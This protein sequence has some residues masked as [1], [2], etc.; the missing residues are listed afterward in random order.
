MD[1]ICC[2]YL[3][4][5]AVIIFETGDIRKFEVTVVKAGAAVGVI[6]HFVDFVLEVIGEE[7]A[8]RKFFGRN[9]RATDLIERNL[10]FGDDVGGREFVPG[11]LITDDV[12]SENEFA[13]VR[14]LFDD[15]GVIFG[16]GGGVGGIDKGEEIAVVNF[17]EVAAFAQL[18]FDGKVVDGVALGV[19]SQNGL[20]D[21]LVFGA[22][23]VIGVENGKN[24]GNNEAL[25]PE[26]GREELFLHFDGVRE[27]AVVRHE[28]HLCQK[29]LKFTVFIFVRLMYRQFFVNLRGFGK[30]QVHCQKCKKHHSPMIGEWCQKVAESLAS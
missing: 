1:H 6:F 10:S 21:E 18:L 20:E 22:I 29:T 4:V 9:G 27:V 17:L 13:Q 19:E 5:A 24:L 11:G 15:V 2:N 14:F 25:V 16:I 12:S 23:K 26:H 28:N 8:E 30:Y 3:V 7:I